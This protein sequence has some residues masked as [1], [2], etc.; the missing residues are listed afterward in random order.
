MFRTQQRNA[1]S[2]LFPLTMTTEY[3]STCYDEVR[4]ECWDLTT[5][6]MCGLRRATQCGVVRKICLVLF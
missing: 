1:L 2:K 3:I 6:R 5:T 4:K